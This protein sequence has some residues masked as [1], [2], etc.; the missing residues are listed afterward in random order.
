MGVCPGAQALA[1]PAA[2]TIPSDPTQ[3]TVALPANICEGR[4]RA[5]LAAGFTGNA[6]SQD[7]AAAARVTAPPARADAEPVRAIVIST[8]LTGR[9]SVGLRRAV[10]GRASF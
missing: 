10:P 5:A 1:A 4:S 8:D 6:T 7:N 3:T 9:S 2:R